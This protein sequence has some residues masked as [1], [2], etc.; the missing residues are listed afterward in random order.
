M[1]IYACNKCGYPY[2]WSSVTMS[3]LP[4]SCPH[5]PEPPDLRWPRPL[6]WSDAD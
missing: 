6:D 5:P 1:G 4:H 3:D 2:G